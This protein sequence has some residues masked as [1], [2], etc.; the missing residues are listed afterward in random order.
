MNSIYYLGLRLLA[1]RPISRALD[2][3][4]YVTPK[5]MRRETV[6]LESRPLATRLC[7]SK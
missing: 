7:I 4:L 5:F 3:T 2:K 1:K 6:A